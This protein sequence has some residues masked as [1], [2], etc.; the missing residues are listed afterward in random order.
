MTLRKGSKKHLSLRTLR[1]NDPVQRGGMEAYNPRKQVREEPLGL[2]Q[3]GTLGL[4]TPKLL[5]DGKRYDLRIG[6][7]LEGLVV[8]AFG[9]EPVVDVVYLA[10]QNSHSL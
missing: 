4:N 1:C 10:E 9:I 8:V 5:E 3:E 7:F 2:A 6:E